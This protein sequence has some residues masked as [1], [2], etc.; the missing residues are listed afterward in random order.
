MPTKW[1]RIVRWGRRGAK[2]TEAV[3]EGGERVELSA[4]QDRR[5]LRRILGRRHEAIAA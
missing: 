3:L 5:P 2:F 4:V 1:G